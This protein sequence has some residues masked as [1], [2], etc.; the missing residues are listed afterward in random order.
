MENTITIWTIQ[1]KLEENKRL[2][3]A[4]NKFLSE[5]LTIYVMAWNNSYDRI[6]GQDEELRKLRRI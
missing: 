4:E 6:R 2:T 5:A 1:K 3:H